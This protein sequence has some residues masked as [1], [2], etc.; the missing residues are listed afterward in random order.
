[1]GHLDRTSKT[2]VHHLEGQGRELGHGHVL[3]FASFRLVIGRVSC[4]SNSSRPH[5]FHSISRESYPHL[6][7]IPLQS[8]TTMLSYAGNEHLNGKMEVPEGYN[9]YQHPEDY[10]MTG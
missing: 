7:R 8:L 6:F 4:L 9:L 5:S 1:M 3:C 10:G 2:Y